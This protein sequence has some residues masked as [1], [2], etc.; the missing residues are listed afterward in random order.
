[1]LPHV[2]SQHVQAQFQGVSC[3]NQRD[4]CWYISWDR[5]IVD[6]AEHMFPDFMA[7]KA[8]LLDKCQ[9][10]RRGFFTNVVKPLFAYFILCVVLCFAESAQRHQELVSRAGLDFY[11]QGSS[12]TCYILCRHDLS[13]LRLHSTDFELYELF[14]IIRIYQDKYGLSRGCNISTNLVYLF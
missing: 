1:M 14:R 6:K 11:N 3:F 4:E 12:S 7:T 5:T 9:E 8:E 10:I 2:V 13:P